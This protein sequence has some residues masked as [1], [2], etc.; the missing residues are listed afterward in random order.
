MEDTEPSELQRGSSTATDVFWF[1]EKPYVSLVN[2]SHTS[3]RGAT[4]DAVTTPDGTSEFPESTSDCCGSNATQ[5]AVA[6]I[7][8]P[9]MQCPSMYD[10]SHHSASPQ[11]EPATP[12]H[13]AD[14]EPSRSDDTERERH[15]IF[16]SQQQPAPASSP[17]LSQRQ[18]LEGPRDASSREAAA[19]PE[20]ARGPGRQQPPSRR[21]FPSQHYRKLSR[22]GGR[23]G[24][25]CTQDDF[26]LDGPNSVIGKGTVGLYAKK[27]SQVNVREALDGSKHAFYTTAAYTSRDPNA[28]NPEVVKERQYRAWRDSLLPKTLYYKFANDPRNRAALRSSRASSHNY[29]FNSYCIPRGCR[30]V[31]KEE[32]M[33]VGRLRAIAAARFQKKKNQEAAKN[34]LIGNLLSRRRRA[35]RGEAIDLPDA[36]YT[37]VTRMNRALDPTKP[38]APLERDAVTA[39]KHHTAYRTNTILVQNARVLHDE[40]VQE[41]ATKEK[42]QRRKEVE[43]AWEAERSFQQKRTEGLPHLSLAQVRAHAS[44]VAEGLRVRAVLGR[45]ERDSRRQQGKAEVAAETEATI[46]RSRLRRRLPHHPEHEG[47]PS[48]TA[49]TSNHRPHPLPTPPPPSMHGAVTGQPTT[50]LGTAAPPQFTTDPAVFSTTTTHFLAE[51]KHWQR[52]F[53]SP[54]PAL[55]S[56]SD[57]AHRRAWLQELAE[58]RGDVNVRTVQLQKQLYPLRTLEARADSYMEKQ[59]MADEGRV[60]GEKNRKQ[61]QAI[62]VRLQERNNALHQQT[63]EQLGRMRAAQSLQLQ[64]RKH[65]AAELRVE[66]AECDEMIH[67]MANEEFSRRREMVLSAAT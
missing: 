7:S 64:E 57:A 18:T 5:P 9:P 21:L 8:S 22:R 11:R 6:P 65:N 59:R 44:T 46:T 32:R 38:A 24:R 31:N 30:V 19:P 61:R 20:L 51:A 16:A 66:S 40:A 42:L 43:A 48:A 50:T 55:P 54:L 4:Y 12:S 56:G 45:L 15:A 52:Q 53:R 13:T 25:K 28:E 27:A 39:S 47:A 36:Y 23:R 60:E 37:I 3:G 62:A 35:V 29:H 33:E 58:A 1:E 41:A 10:C 26:F 14:D 2:T 63:V 67:S 49:A 17:P 34:A